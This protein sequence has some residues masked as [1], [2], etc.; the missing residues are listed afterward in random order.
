MVRSS[1][2]AKTLNPKYDETFYIGLDV[3]ALSEDNITLS[4]EAYDWD[5]IGKIGSN[6]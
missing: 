2:K 3:F 4:I 1:T 5:I 6:Y